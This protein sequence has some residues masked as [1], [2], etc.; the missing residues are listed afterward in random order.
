MELTLRRPDDWHLH[1]RDGAVLQDV[2]PLVARRFARAICMPNLRP[3]VTT[4]E[5]A[6][7]YRKRILAALP[8]GLD[9]EPLMTR[10]LTDRTAPRDIEEAAGYRF[11]FLGVENVRGPNYVAAQGHFQVF[12]GEKQIAELRP[13]KRKYLASQ[14]PM[15]EASI[16]WGLTRDLYVSLGEPVGEAG[17]W[18]LRIYYKPY[19]R[20]IWLGAVLMAIGGILAVTDRRYRNV[21]ETVKMPA[22]GAATAKG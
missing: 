13:E 6:R 22:A 4:V 3:P 11:K 19:V 15:T 12:E 1:L 21:R 20:W 14:K 17:D 18:A 2:V 16:D 9:F 7:A 5:Q 8:A 10:Y